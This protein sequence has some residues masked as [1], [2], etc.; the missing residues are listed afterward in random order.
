MADLKKNTDVAVTATVTKRY[1]SLRV[2]KISGPGSAPVETTIPASTTSGGRGADSNSGYVTTDY[3]L[4]VNQV[5]FSKKNITIENNVV[6]LK[7]TGGI[8]S[9][10]TLYETVDDPLFKIGEQVVV[11][12][13]QYAPGKFMVSGGP[14]GRFS[15]SDGK[16]SAVVKDGVQVNDVPVNSFNHLVARA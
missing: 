10:D 1:A 5:V 16:V 8:G 13:I 12:L 9:N 7:Q 15:V 3:D 14:S 4:S 11:F 6:R 2:I